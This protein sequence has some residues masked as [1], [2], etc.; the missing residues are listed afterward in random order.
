MLKYDLK[1][2]GI[3]PAIG[4]TPIVELQNINPYK[5]VRILAKLEG[6]NPGG[7]VKDRP[8]YYMLK[9]AI[10]IGEL[11]RDKII[12]E[13]T[14][15]NT[16]IGLAMVGAALGFNVTLCMPECVS[17]ERQAILQA[18]GANLVL[19]DGC[20]NID[21]AILKGREM[22]ERNPDKYYMPDQYS[23]PAN[24][25]SHYETTAPEIIEQTN[26]EITA[27]VA[28]LGTSG[29]IMGVSKRLKEFN[30]KIQV[31]AVEPPL[32]HTIQGLKNMNE[33][34][35]PKIYNPSLLDEII[36]IN[37]E[38]AFSITRN[39]ATEEGLLCG[40]S[41]GAAV[42]GALAIAEKLTD[43]TIVTIL[44]DRGDRY[45]STT[46]FKSICAQCPP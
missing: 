8:V 2:L 45:L 13:S 18:F 36:T 43:G 19:T 35:V 34:I 28:G 27:F 1:N 15:G 22:I 21:G 38:T 3:I 24:V 7:S 17:L 11:T 39:L 6:S 32:G 37:D 4:N 41:S 10:E 25:L 9:K 46:L 30:P 31:I 42:A 16:G 12:L 20:K 26:G 5:N 23:N 33:A 14:S 29:T 40:M 44:P